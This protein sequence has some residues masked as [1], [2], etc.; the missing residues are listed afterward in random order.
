MSLQSNTIEAF[1]LLELEQLPEEWVARLWEH[2]FCESDSFTSQARMHI[3]GRYNLATNLGQQKNGSYIEC[4]V[5][6][7]RVGV[8]EQPW[9]A[10][11]SGSMQG[12]ADCL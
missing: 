1:R 3:Y 8:S 2:N 7:A 10:V 5:M 6:Y 12:V 9:V 11:S 4:N